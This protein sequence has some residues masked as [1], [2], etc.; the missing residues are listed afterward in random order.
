MANVTD[1]VVVGS[2][3]AGMTAALSAAV[4]GSKVTVIERAPVFGGTTAISGGGM[5]L[6]RNASGQALGIEDSEEAVRTYLNRV[7]F[8][9]TA[10]DVLMS[11]IENAPK[12]AD[13]IVENSPVVLDG[14]H[15]ADYLTNLPGAHT[16]GRQVAPGLYDTNRLGEW[17]DK[18]RIGP[19]PTTI[20]FVTQKE[21]ESLPDIGKVGWERIQTGISGRGRGLVAGL[22]EP[23]LALGVEFVNNARLVGLTQ[24]CGRVDGVELLHDSR[25]ERIRARHGVI[26][27]SGGF[28]WNRSLWRSLIGVPFD[29]PLSPPYNEGDG[30]VAAARVGAKLGSLNDVW[31]MP[32]YAKP[33][34]TYDG[35]PRLRSKPNRGLPHGIVVNRRGRRFVNESINYNDFGKLQVAFDPHPYEFVNAPS[36]HIFDQ[37]HRDKYPILENEDEPVEGW[38]VSAPTIRELAERLG[39]DPEGLE[40]QVA[41]FNRNAEQGIDPVFHRGEAR[42]ERK[43]YTWERYKVDD[44]FGPSNPAIAPLSTPPFYGLEL[45][46]G[47]FGTKGGVVINSHGQ[48]IDWNDNP[49][50]G[51]YAAGNVA[52][53][54]FGPAYPGGGSTLGPAVT[55]GYLAGKA[56]AS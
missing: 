10:E 45:K 24:S 20:V 2:G 4:A 51:L 12:T 26:L 46:I 50:P 39:I 49:I 17:K 9:R 36:F 55:F 31:W 47:C 6:P 56:I 33:G 53:T 30:L 34:D 32:S 48:A 40:S 15:V 1:V 52:A 5:W 11:F 43:H 13:F 29:G 54:V 3:G 27:A 42:W 7:T 38:P 37:E 14:T 19:W 44:P 21:K 18:V 23:C 28:E 35:R 25:P 8:G 41:E 22:M 16:E